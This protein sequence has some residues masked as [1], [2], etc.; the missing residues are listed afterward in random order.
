MDCFL[1]FP[2]E[3]QSQLLRE[4]TRHQARKE[5]F[6]APPTAAKSAPAAPAP[7]PKLTLPQTLALQ[8]GGPSFFIFDPVEV[9]GEGSQSK[10]LELKIKLRSRFGLWKSQRFLFI[11][12]C[13]FQT[14]PLVFCKFVVLKNLRHDLMQGFSDP[15]FQSKRKAG[16]WA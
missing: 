12:L 1:I 7:P 9:K 15:E 6:P 8:L 13:F 2:A 5:A 3:I 11:F 4:T 16:G 10:N 14:K